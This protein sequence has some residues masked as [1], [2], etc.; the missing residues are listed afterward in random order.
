ME[1][2][3]LYFRVLHAIASVSQNLVATQTLFEIFEIEYDTNKR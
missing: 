3:L 1:E 2:T